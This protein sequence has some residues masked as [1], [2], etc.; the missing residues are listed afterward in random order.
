MPIP[1]VTL[2]HNTTHNSQNCGV[3]IALV[4]DTWPPVTTEPAVGDSGVHPCG[5]QSGLGTRTSIQPSDMNT[6]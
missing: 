2:K 4:A 3:L 1:A 6:A 5:F